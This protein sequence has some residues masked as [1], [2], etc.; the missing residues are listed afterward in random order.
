MNIKLPDIQHEMSPPIPIKI[1][2]V[3]VQNIVTRFLLELNGNGY[4]E[5]LAN[6]SMSTNL[7]STKKGISMSMLLRSLL[8]YID[9]PLK[10]E[11]IE[12]IL[13]DQRKAVETDSNDSFIKF[14]FK[15]PIRKVAPI[16]KLEFPQFYYCSFEGR[17][18]GEVFRFF[19]RVVVNYTSYCP[20][21]A[22]L[23]T[24][25]LMSK[26]H[27][28]FPHAQR[29]SADVLVEVNLPSVLWLEEIIEIVEK[30]VVNIPIPILRRVDEQEFARIAGENPMFVEDAIRF[31]S[32]GLDK[33]NRIF[34]WIV[35]CVHEESIHTHEAIAINW[36]GIRGGFDGL[37]FL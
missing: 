22:S 32:D 14:D 17:L 36:K 16:S 21:S 25:L 29:S 19:Q 7:D 6:V 18:T 15:L 35:K 30:A 2:Q 27:G 11:L 13:R 23:C 1:G 5:L 26:G 24:H 34:D 3:G 37:K 31:I 8:N 9:K 33:E 10:H 28:G 4:H 12:N 20:C